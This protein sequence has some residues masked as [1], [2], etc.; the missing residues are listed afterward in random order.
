M[1]SVRRYYSCCHPTNQRKVQI[2][3]EHPSRS[4]NRDLMAA[5]RYSLWQTELR[6]N[7]EIRDWERSGYG[8]LGKRVT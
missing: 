1:R 5:I 4:S 7:Y 3:L 8:L 2:E 6:M